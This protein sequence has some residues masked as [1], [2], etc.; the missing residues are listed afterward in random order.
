VLPWGEIQECIAAV[1]DFV[2]GGNAALEQL[3]KREGRGGQTDL[4]ARLVVTKPYLAN[5]YD[6]ALNFCKRICPPEK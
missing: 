6:H 2:L 1:K 3:L 5:F 4:A